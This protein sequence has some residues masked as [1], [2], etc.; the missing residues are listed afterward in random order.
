[1]FQFP[2]CRLLRTMYSS[3]DHQLLLAGLPHSEI[4]GSKP[5]YSS[6]K[7]IAVSHVLLRLLM[8]RHSPF[9]LSSL[10]L[11]YKYYQLK[12]LCLRCGKILANSTTLKMP[13]EYFI[14]TKSIPT[15]HD[16]HLRKCIACLPNIHFSKNAL[17]PRSHRMLVHP[18]RTRSKT[19]WITEVNQ[20]HHP[21]RTVLK[22]FNLQQ[23][24]YIKKLDE[25]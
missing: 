18:R 11:F 10:A 8:P 13:Q 14:L 9:A 15:T 25:D 5:D 1:M 23:I 22:T 7:L 4:S 16:A 3:G 24:S 19:R 6:P 21:R 2:K 20:L 17:R 12:T